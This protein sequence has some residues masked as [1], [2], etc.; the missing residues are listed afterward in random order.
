MLC[1]FFSMFWSLAVS[2][3]G[4]FDRA[5]NSRIAGLHAALCDRHHIG[6]G[7]AA[8][9]N[10]GLVMHLALHVVAIT[11]GSRWMEDA[12]G[13]GRRLCGTLDLSLRLS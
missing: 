11:V 9:A 6:A 13:R 12:R 1:L 8:A 4:S 2:A 3:S 5:R 7:P 10:D